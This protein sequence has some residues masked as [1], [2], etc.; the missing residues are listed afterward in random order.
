MYLER[1]LPDNQHGFR[2]NRGTLSAW[3]EF[4]EKKVNESENIWEYDF[5]KYF[6]TINLQHLGEILRALKLPTQIVTLLISIN[7]TRPTNWMEWKSK[8]VEWK[9][10]TN[11]EESNQR[12][13]HMAICEAMLNMFKG[14]IFFG[15]DEF[16]S[17]NFR[18]E[19]L[20]YGIEYIKDKSLSI[21]QGVAQGSPTSPLLAIL[22]LQVIKD[23]KIIQ[24]ADDGF[25]YGSSD[26]DTQL[27]E[28]IPKDSGIKINEEKSG[29]VKR[30]NI[31][32]KPL[33]FLGLEFDGIT[34]KAK[35]RKGA[36]LILDQKRL[37]LIEEHL[38]DREDTPQSQF[39]K[40]GP[41]WQ[42]YF[43]SKLTGFIQS[44]L[45]QNNWD[46]KDLEQDFQMSFINNSWM[47]SKLNKTPSRL[48]IYNSSSFASDSLIN[49]FRWNAKLRKARRRPLKV[50]FILSKK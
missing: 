42:E 11:L 36:D 23:K 35:T 14:P 25:I 16:K 9:T 6:D 17:E 43:R 24:Y 30:N 13:R 37:D 3:K 44:R 27:R 2:P 10:P 34:L 1:H 7:L 48:T 40:N 41:S 31:W 32:V 29:W 15:Q 49:V 45:Y 50:R 8:I 26:V 21:F 4:F 47:T 46:I 22:P 5:E 33:K 20:R 28:M 39:I 19:W 18:K 38:I 12:W